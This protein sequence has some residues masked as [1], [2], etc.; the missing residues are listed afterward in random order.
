MSK[1]LA[2]LATI[3]SD[4]HSWNL[5]FMEKFLIETGFA[6]I[7][8]GVCVPY[9]DVLVNCAT[10][11]PDYLVISTINGHGYME[12]VELAKI[13]RAE[14]NL[15]NMKMVIGGNLY[16]GSRILGKHINGLYAAGYDGVYSSANS[17]QEFSSL[18]IRQASSS[19]HPVP[20][21]VE[22]A[23]A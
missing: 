21:Y 20:G 12:G 22:Q 16:V 14:I 5:I 6:T 8:L 10:H 9:E 18:L 11:K 2:I 4:S 19:L 23:K 17:L 3:P 7:N 15:T 13:I 1:G